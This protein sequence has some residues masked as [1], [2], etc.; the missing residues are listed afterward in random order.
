M[1]G[2]RAGHIQEILSSEFSIGLSLYFTCSLNS[3]EHAEDDGPPAPG[4]R[5]HFHRASSFQVNNS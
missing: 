1:Y 2:T 4:V 5:G 3:A